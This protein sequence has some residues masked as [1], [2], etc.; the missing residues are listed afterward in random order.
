ME[1]MHAVLGLGVMGAATLAELAR[2]G[3]RVVGV[4]Q[5][6]LVHARGSSHGQSRIIRTAYYEHPAYVPLVR[7]AF[8]QWRRLER[9]A[10]QSLLLPSPCLSLGAADGELLS[11]V[12]RAANEHGLPIESLTAAEVMRRYPAFRL[13]DEI[14]GILEHDAGVLRVEACVRAMLDDA[15][16]HGATVHAAMPVLHWR[17]TADGVEL[18]TDGASI[19]ADNLIITAGAWAT[20]FL[21]DMG[22]SL[23]VMRQTMHWFA[24]PADVPI[25]MLDWPGGA[26]YGLP[27]IDGR[28]PKIARH[29]GAP[30][31][32]SPDDVSWETTAD[33]SLA[34]R[35]FLDRYLPAM[36]PETASHVCQ[37]TLTPDRHFAIDR[38]PHHANVWYAAGFSGHG[39]KFAPTIGTILADLATVGTTGFD[40]GLFS[41]CRFDG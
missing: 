23:T 29:Y 36:G 32:P 27:G 19:R 13:P 17:A 33:D 21:K 22:L 40:I 37:Y 1:F 14:S 15:V 6:P 31:L 30:E 11:G 10:G 39:F 41:Q 34:V 35:G 26:F 4:E 7:D 3:Q 28:G 16:R 38:H 8:Q 18:T 24:G 2:R 9:D 25:F 20:K 5:F 12:R